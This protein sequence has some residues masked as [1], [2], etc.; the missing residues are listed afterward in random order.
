MHDTL[1]VERLL[2]STNLLETLL[3][4]LETIGSAL[5]KQITPFELDKILSR[6]AQV[7]HMLTAC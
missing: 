7:I 4:V 2:T 6:F 3:F 5:L 1:L